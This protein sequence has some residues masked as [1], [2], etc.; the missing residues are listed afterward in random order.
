M[1]DVFNSLANLSRDGSAGVLCT[2]IKTIGSTPRKEGSKMLVYPDG[3]IVGSVGGGEVEGRVIQEAI[4][5]LESGETKV[6]S[7]DLMDP[8]KGDP[9]VCGGTMEV[10][11]DP[12][13]S[14]DDIV[15]VGGGH[16][17]RAVVHLAKWMGF[18]VILSDDRQEFCNPET[19]PGADQY[20]HCNLED[21]PTHYNFSKHTAIILVTRSNQVDINGLPEILAEPL[22]YIG[23]ISSQRR[24]RLTEE[25]LLE[26]GVKKE[27]LKKINA[28]I[29]I[30]IQAHTPEEIA[31][32]IMA[33]VLLVKR[34]GT[35]IP[36]SKKK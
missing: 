8:G 4:A 26:S 28:P 25:Q 17:G 10:F 30:D 36:L 35:G 9:G 18:R 34:N 6:L 22:A 20:I 16:V 2:I 3:K 1:G 7:Y 32:S 12:L 15:I 23:V 24:W 13:Q 14:P 21:L 31:L 11:I 5:A 33:E 19:S 29:G 27:A